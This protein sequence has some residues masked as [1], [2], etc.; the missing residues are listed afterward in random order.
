MTAAGRGVSDEILMRFMEEI[1]SDVNDIKAA[2]SLNSTN[3]AVVSKDLKSHKES[4]TTINMYLMI[5][6]FTVGLVGG[7]LGYIFGAKQNNNGAKESVQSSV[8]ITD[9]YY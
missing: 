7:L 8:K 6:F 1:R 5:I 2:I 9:R 4:R 3:I